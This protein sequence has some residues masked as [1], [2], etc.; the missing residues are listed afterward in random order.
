MQVKP[1]YL[2]LSYMELRKDMLTRIPLLE[3]TSIIEILIMYQ[4]LLQV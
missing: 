3:M 2:M 4:V 1:I